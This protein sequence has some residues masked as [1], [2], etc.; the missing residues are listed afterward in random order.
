MV[1]QIYFLKCLQ[2]S[3]TQIKHTYN[4]SAAVNKLLVIWNYIFYLTHTHT[5]THTHTKQKER[6]K[7][8]EKKE[9]KSKRKKMKSLVD[10]CGYTIKYKASPLERSLECCGS[11]TPSAW[12]AGSRN[13]EA[14]RASLTEGWGARPVSLGEVGLPPASRRLFLRS[15]RPGGLLLL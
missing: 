8:T 4:Y 12:N 6:K 13:T 11:S 10:P 2:I 15:L 9:K 14:A 3:S 7:E 5:H 1:S